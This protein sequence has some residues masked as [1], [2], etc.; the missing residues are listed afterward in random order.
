MA[1]SG[2]TAPADRRATAESIMEAHEYETMFSVEDRHWWYVGMRRI[3]SQLVTR[4]YP[5]RTGLCILD[6]GCGTGAMIDELTRFG[7]VT[8]CDLSATALEYCRRRGLS[9][10][11]RASVVRLPFRD[12]T[13]DLVTSFEVVSHRGVGDCEGA[14]IEFRRVLKPGGRL[15]LRLPAYAW[16]YSRHDEAVHTGRRFTAGE[17]RRALEASRFIVQK[18]SYANTLMFPLALVKRV[19]GG[20]APRRRTARS[21]LR[22][23][24]AWQDRLLGRVL[25]A[26]ASWIAHHSFPFGLSVLAVGEKPPAGDRSGEP[27][28]QH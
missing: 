5:G 11:S 14:L 3:T 15:L 23:N 4:Y 7:T 16:L 8:G 27:A 28:A 13:F 2:A 22:P 24:P 21:E 17:V 1:E 26:E 12:E 6:A 19:A 25:A 20:I 10:L 18:L 9:R